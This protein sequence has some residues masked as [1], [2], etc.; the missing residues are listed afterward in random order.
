MPLL[1]VDQHLVGGGHS[2]DGDA[3]RGAE[4]NVP[5]TAAIE[6]GELVEVGLQ[7]LLAQ[8]VVDAERPGFQVG[9]DAVG[10]RQDDVGGHRADDVRVSWM[11]PGAPG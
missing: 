10:L 8:A 3:E 1:P 11:T 4:G 6:A 9:E 2:G 5:G 7:A